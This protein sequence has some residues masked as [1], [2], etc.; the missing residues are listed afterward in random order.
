MK[1]IVISGYYGFGNTGD[2]AALA[3]TLAS[4]RSLDENVGFTVLS[5]NPVET[6][7]AHGVPAEPRFSL[8]AVVRAIRKADL[9]ISGG[10][11]IFQDATS[12]RSATYYF[13]V[14][15]IAKIL[16]KPVMLYAQ[17]IG[18]I[19]R[20]LTKAQVRLI[21]N[22]VNL[23][24][25]RDEDSAVLLRGLGVTVPPIHVT[26]DASFALEPEGDDVCASVLE[27]AGVPAE[28][29]KLGVALRSWR[30]G[31]DWPRVVADGIAATVARI[32]AVPVFIPMQYPDDVQ[33]AEAV[34]AAVGGESVI[35]RER[36]APVS[37]KAA[38]GRMDVVLAM[39][40]HA[41]LFAAAQGVPFAALSYDPKVA[42]F[43]KTIPG[44]P[45]VEAASLTSQDIADSIQSVWENRPVLSAAL[46]A[47]LPD[48]RREAL[49]NARL[50][51]D[52]LGAKSLPS[53]Y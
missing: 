28:R 35:L 19:T 49:R 42:A 52:L 13:G 5:A 16:C 33:L 31:E 50:S 40:L 43:A 4:F 14:I 39:R 20:S 22:R 38:I 44:L 46:S 24:T 21:L 10:G 2:E 9:L 32:G 30:V 29:P 7:T 41:A 23:I 8:P 17:G 3:G 53:R 45:I 26:A 11:S 27:K 51:L 15:L 6:A 48:W 12:A 18:P 47:R 36:L 34:A 25:V 1:H 37:V